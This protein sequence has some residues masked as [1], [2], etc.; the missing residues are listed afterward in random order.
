[1]TTSATGPEPSTQPAEPLRDRVAIVTG[2]GQGI[3]RVL[4]QAFATAGASVVVADKDR[5]RAEA[6]AADLV[7]QGHSALA[8]EADVSEQSSVSEMVGSTVRSLGRIDVLVNNAAIFSTITMKPFEEISLAE[9]NQVIAVN[10]TGVFLCCQA[11]AGQMRQQQSGR[12]IN[13]SSG[14]VLSGRPNYLHYVTSKAGVA[15]MTRVLARELGP[16]G[17]TVNTIMPGSVGTEIVRETV[18]AEQIAEIVAGQAIRR[19]VVPED[20]AATAVF[21]ASE[22][23]GAISGQTIVVDGGH[24]FV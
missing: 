6:V 18:T 17:I 10:L 8:V 16:S 3:G 13:L 11:V 20:I 9:W 19:R 23:A 2:G 4:S 12:I 14:T 5:A 21:L 15:G 1:M 7:A 22:S 24:D